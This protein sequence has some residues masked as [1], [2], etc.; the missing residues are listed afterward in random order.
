MIFDSHGAWTLETKSDAKGILNDFRGEQTLSDVISLQMKLYK[1]KGSA[2][3]NEWRDPNNADNPYR[4]RSVNH[5][6]RLQYP[7]FT[8]EEVNELGQR[9]RDYYSQVAEQVN[10]REIEVT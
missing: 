6:S 1:A 3:Q 9:G 2:I 10:E 4:G 5:P 8:V 7:P